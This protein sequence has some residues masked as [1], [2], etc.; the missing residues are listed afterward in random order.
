MTQ[1]E[2]NNLLQ[3]LCSEDESNVLMA[4]QIFRGFN[5]IP[6]CLQLAL[7]W[8]CYSEYHQVRIEA[9][10]LMEERIGKEM[11]AEL[12]NSL[13]VLVKGD[14]DKYIVFED[15]I[16]ALKLNNSEMLQAFYAHR[17]SYARLIKMNSN[18]LKIC[19][20]AGIFWMYHG[21]RYTPK[22]RIFFEM[23]LQSYPTHPY[24]LFC[25][26]HNYQCTEKQKKKALQYYQ[27][28][29]KYHPNVTATDS[30]KEV[31]RNV[32]YVDIDLPTTMNAYQNIAYCYHFYLQNNTK[33]I[34]YYRKAKEC[35]SEN[36]AFAFDSFA[37]LLWTHSRNAALALQIAQ[38]GLTLLERKDLPQELFF[39][40]LSF[41]I[42]NR[43]SRLR[44]LIEEIQQ[45]K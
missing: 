6:K 19:L 33:A 18:Y 24:A 32:F 34:H 39:G 27:L 20:Q 1:K 22:T 42:Y 31:Y 30:M 25:L 17:D 45:N 43:K 3:L 2:I 40:I 14:T 4:I 13:V 44:E 5:K 36:H 35:I 9:Q 41:T 15:H 26:A 29:L 7:S 8:A 11:L 23:I 28:F 10:S 21:K 38:E 37:K 12:T 16:K